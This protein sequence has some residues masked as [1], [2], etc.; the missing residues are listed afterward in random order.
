MHNAF[1]NEKTMP[2]RLSILQVFEEVK[3]VFQ[4]DASQEEE[5]KLASYSDSILML[6]IAIATGALLYL[7]FFWLDKALFPDTYHLVWIARGLIIAGFTTELILTFQS[8]FPKVHQ[9]SIFFLMCMIAGGQFFFLYITFGLPQS[10]DF[11]FIGLLLIITCAFGLTQMHLKNCILFTV[12]IVATYLA[13]GVFL[14]GWAENGWF[15]VDGLRMQYNASFLAGIGILGTIIYITLQYYRR[16]NFLSQLDIKKE[17]KITEG[18]LLNILPEKI[19]TRLKSSNEIIADEHLEVSILFADI[20]NF[21]NLFDSN[22]PK[23]L[24]EFLNNLFSKF[25]V[26]AST[27]GLE[28]IKTIGDAYMAV[29]G[30]T[31][32]N[33]HHLSFMAKLALEMNE[34]LI[35]F[36]HENNMNV[37]LRTGIHAGKV[38]AGVIGQSKFAFDLWGDAVNIAS[39]M[40]SSSLP[41]KIQVTENLMRKL[42]DEFVFEERGEINV[43]GKGQL[44]TYFLLRES[45]VMIEQ[46]QPMSQSA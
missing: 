15:A 6:R 37:Q 46:Q 20:V 14:F 40:E 17:K 28:K 43:K 44:R 4:L 25:D 2:S 36:N 19:A 1:L 23:S 16:K 35:Q 7:T 9:F 29:G 33:P 34:A 8:Y 38:V 18:L 21:T 32:E 11:Y 31:I 12:L 42:G 30:L 45:G 27:Y 3:S 41:G 39:R 10:H 5:Y 13:F 22:N 24:V 26:L